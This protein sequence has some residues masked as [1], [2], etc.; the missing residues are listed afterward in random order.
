MTQGD[1][2]STARSLRRAVATREDDAF[3]SDERNHFCARLHPGA[4]LGEEKLAAGEVAAGRGQE[5]GYLQ[6]KEHLAVD[7]LVQAIVVVLFVAQEERRGPTLSCV[8]AAVE[9]VGMT[10]RI[11]VGPAEEVLP[12]IRDRSEVLVKRRPQV[13][14]DLR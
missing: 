13:R 4:L 1:P 11:P 10:R 14:D 12:P 7:V 5:E 6:R 3:S 8:A 9:K 2:V